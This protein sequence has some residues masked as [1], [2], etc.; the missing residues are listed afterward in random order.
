MHMD[1]GIR[2]FKVEREEGF[3]GNIQ[4]WIRG[5]R[6]ICNEDRVIQEAGG[7]KGLNMHRKCQTRK[8]EQTAS[9]CPTI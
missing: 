4:G 3:K 1:R 6:F 5:N 7:V 8:G 9:I 2:E